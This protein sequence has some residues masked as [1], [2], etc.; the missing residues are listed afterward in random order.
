MKTAEDFYRTMYGKS[1]DTICKACR[2]ENQ[3]RWAMKNHERTLRY[4]R[5]YAERNAER[6]RER[7]RE[8]NLR[9]YREGY[10]RPRNPLKAWARGTVNNAIRYGKI[11]RPD[12]CSR[13]GETG[14]MIDA[15]HHDYNKPLEIEWL[16]RRCHGVEHRVEVARYD[17]RGTARDEFQGGITA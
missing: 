16:C 9:R 15:H 13:C 14:G 7:V 5:D 11:I 8:K 3:S 10:R 12:Q 4:K 1:R 17:G 2:I 6:E